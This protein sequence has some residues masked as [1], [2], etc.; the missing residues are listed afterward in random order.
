M[1]FILLIKTDAWISIRK[2]NA[3]PFN[4]IRRQLRFSISKES[5]NS[6]HRIMEE[7]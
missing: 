6:F 1:Q 7:V 4:R 3:N 5:A 2:E